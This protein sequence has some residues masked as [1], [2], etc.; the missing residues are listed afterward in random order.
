L[1]PDTPIEDRHYAGSF[2]F[3][4][5]EHAEHSG[6]QAFLIDLTAPVLRL[7]Q[8]QPDLKHQISVQLLPVSIPGGPK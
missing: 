2:S 1:K 6:K 4:G 8:V 5:A 7:R 3:F